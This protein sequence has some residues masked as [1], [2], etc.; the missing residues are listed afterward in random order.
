MSL[1]GRLFGGSNDNDMAESEAIEWG[2]ENAYTDWQ[3]KRHQYEQMQEAQRSADRAE[4]EAEQRMYADRA[5]RY[6]KERKERAARVRANGG[7]WI[8]LEDGSF[9]D[10]DGNILSRSDM[11][12]AY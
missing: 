2:I 4:Y 12:G 3:I 11:L 8:E 9:I 1:L 5:K 7:Q 10:G 6:E